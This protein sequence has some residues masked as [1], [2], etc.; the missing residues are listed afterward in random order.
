MCGG[1]KIGCR[2]KWFL[3]KTEC[4]FCQWHTYDTM[5]VLWASVC[6][7]IGLLGNSGMVA[8]YQI[9]PKQKGSKA[10]FL[11]IRG[12][13]NSEELKPFPLFCKWE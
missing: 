12:V 5:T 6:V 13:K 4:V 7:D 1:K 3:K 10:G 11:C 8:D 9:L 2:K